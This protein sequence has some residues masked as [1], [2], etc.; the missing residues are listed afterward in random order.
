[1]DINF[2][3]HKLINIFIFLPIHI[4]ISPSGLMY[5]IILCVNPIYFKII[6]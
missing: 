5:D 6:E 3:M 4:V 1:M 2:N